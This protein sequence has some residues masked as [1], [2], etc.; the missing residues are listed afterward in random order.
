MGRDTNRTWH[1]SVNNTGVCVC[2]YSVCLYYKYSLNWT[3]EREREKKNIYIA[4][5]YIVALRQKGFDCLIQRLSLYYT[6]A[7]TPTHTHPRTHV[8]N[9]NLNWRR[10]NK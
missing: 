5:F 4:K 8:H 1:A 2:V 9:K 3:G 10:I 6:H 7:H